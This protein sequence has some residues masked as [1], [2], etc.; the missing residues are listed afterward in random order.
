MNLAE[1]VKYVL[2]SKSQH[3]FGDFWRDDFK[4]ILNEFK[5]DIAHLFKT[6]GQHFSQ[7][8]KEGLKISIREMLTS[9]SDILAVFKIVPRRVK[10]GFKFFRDDFVSEIEKQSD[11]KQKTVY[12]LKVL[13]ALSSFIIGAIYNLKVGQAD[14]NFVGLK[15]KSAF[16]QFLV[17][18]L[19]FKI[20]QVLI[21]R[22][23]TEVEKHVED[24][25]ELN[26][27]RYF[28]ALFSDRDK[29]ESEREN[30]PEDVPKDDPAIVIVDNLKSYI[31]TGKRL[32]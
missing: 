7:F 26:N 23:L 22:F 17:A 9:A 11:Q 13:G 27:V 16:T 1:S 21:V 8:R 28:R 30:L 24:P 18:E 20:S 5:H 10:E 15:R 25:D 32:S 2:K 19:V 3:L 29:M 12:V 31:M 6:S 14:F 4:N